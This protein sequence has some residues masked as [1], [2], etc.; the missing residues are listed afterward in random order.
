MADSRKLIFISNDDGY[1]ARGINY[2]AE[3]LRPL[4]DI[5]VVAPESGRSGAAC[6]ITASVSVTVRR[7]KEEPG[8]SVY[9]CSGT[10]VDCVKLAF[11]HILPRRPDIVVS[12]INHGDNAS[13]NVHYSGTLGVAAE[14]AMQ[15]VRSVA[16]SFCNSDPQA[17]ML[18]LKPYVTDIVAKA[19]LHDMPELTLLNV[20]FP[21]VTRFSGVKICTMC[22]SRWL[23]DFSKVHIEGRGDYY[24]LTGNWTNTDPDNTHTDSYALEHGYVAVTPTTLDVSSRELM[25]EVSHWNIGQ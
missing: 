19:L 25:E 7:I 20:N 21:N 4:G 24:F 23:H 16:F 8:L 15:R 2:L 17:D 14:G 1:T 22:H 11:D 6:S 10:P 5:I 9:A 13:L 12:G 3:W 18:H